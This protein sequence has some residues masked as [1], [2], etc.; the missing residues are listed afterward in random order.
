MVQKTGPLHYCN[1]MLKEIMKCSTIQRGNVNRGHAATIIA[2]NVQKG[3][4]FHGHRPRYVSIRQSPHR[5]LSAV[6]Q[7]RPHSDAAAVG[8]FTSFKSHPEWSL[9]ILLLQVLSPIC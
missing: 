7:T 2:T 4:Q 8:F 3:I 9:S 6:R 5:Q 1:K